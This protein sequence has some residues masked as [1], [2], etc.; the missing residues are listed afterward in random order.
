MSIKIAYEIIMHPDPAK[1][2][3]LTNIA[4]WGLEQDTTRLR[5]YDERIVMADISKVQ[6]L[7]GFSAL[8]LLVIDHWSI[9]RAFCMSLILLSLEVGCA[10]LATVP[11]TCTPLWNIQKRCAHLGLYVW[12]GSKWYITLSNIET[13]STPFSMWVQVVSKYG[14]STCL[15]TH[16]HIYN[17]IYNYIYTVYFYLY[18]HHNLQDQPLLR[19]GPTTRHPTTLTNAFGLLAPWDCLSLSRGPDQEFG[20]YIVVLFMLFT[21]FTLYIWLLVYIISYF[22]V[23][24]WYDI[25][26]RWTCI[27]VWS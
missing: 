10:L 25:S 1:A 12:N 11:S 16:T 22:F 23:L 21:I 4:I 15:P 17:Y 20:W 19:M 13:C 27:S 26:C 6:K 2:K 9:S 7:T 5:L 14:D 18:I 3:I 24:L 8:F